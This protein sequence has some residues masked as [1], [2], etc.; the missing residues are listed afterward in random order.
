MTTRQYVVQRYGGSMVCC[1]AE[2]L[3]VA[4]HDSE[5]LAALL[6]WMYAFMLEE[7]G[8]LERIH[9]LEQIC[10][11][12]LPRIQLTGFSH[13]DPLPEAFAGPRPDQ[14][15]SRASGSVPLCVQRALQAELDA[16]KRASKDAYTLLGHIYTKHPPRG[17][18]HVVPSEVRAQN[19]KKAVL[20][21]LRDYHP[22]RCRS[23]D[24]DDAWYALCC[25]IT[26]ALTERH[27]V[28]RHS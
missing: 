1:L 12:S 9:A 10:D 2:D 20:N 19:I 8:A 21:A 27:D 16:L 25:E 18:P 13:V 14:F 22:D 6:A 7:V 15:S 17:R 4:L 11:E 28:L 24:R 23:V 26:K 5:Q 3:L